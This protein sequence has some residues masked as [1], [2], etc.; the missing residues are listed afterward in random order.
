[1]EGIVLTEPSIVSLALSDSGLIL[2]G[3]LLVLFGLAL[4]LTFVLQTSK[5]AHAAL[6]ATLAVIFLL[7]VG[8]ITLDLYGT[9]NSF[10]TFSTTRTLSDA[11]STHRWLLIQLP[12]LLTLSSVIILATYHNRIADAHAKDYRRIVQLSTVVSFVSVLLIALESML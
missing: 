6:T 11:L 7:L 12:V 1:M 8:I 5:H 9:A 10:Y 3:A 2:F 4:G